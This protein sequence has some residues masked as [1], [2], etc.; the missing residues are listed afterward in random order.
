MFSLMFV[1]CLAAGG[2]VDVF[3]DVCWLLGGWGRC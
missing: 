3:V 2:V 1:G